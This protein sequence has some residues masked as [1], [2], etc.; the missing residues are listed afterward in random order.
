MIRIKVF[1]HDEFPSDKIDVGNIS[2]YYCE[3]EGELRFVVSNWVWQGPRREEQLKSYYRIC[4]EFTYPN[5]F[6][7]LHYPE[8]K[9]Q[10]EGFN[11]VPVSQIKEVFESFLKFVETELTV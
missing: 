8:D 6:S 2:F 1:E 4:E 7:L 3:T 9:Y 5:W 11:I 10:E